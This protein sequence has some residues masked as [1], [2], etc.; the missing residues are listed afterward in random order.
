MAEMSSFLSLCHYL[1]LARHVFG[2]WSCLPALTLSPC[3]CLSF[4]RR[5]PALLHYPMSGSIWCHGYHCLHFWLLW[6][7]AQTLNFLLDGFDLVGRA[8]TGCGK[9]LAFVLPIVERLGQNPN[10]QHGRAP[11]VIVLAPTRELA[12]QASS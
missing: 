1:Q 2:C 8:R 12:K 3:S 11:R 6:L 5:S 7:Q 9:T 4:W 10:R